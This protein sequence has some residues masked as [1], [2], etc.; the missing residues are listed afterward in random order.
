MP[1]QVDTLLCKLGYS[2]VNNNV[3]EGGV[4]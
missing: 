4:C 1:E 2:K 3:V